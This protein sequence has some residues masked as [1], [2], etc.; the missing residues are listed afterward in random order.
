MESPSARADQVVI[1]E[2]WIREQL[3]RAG[4]S[5]YEATVA[6]DGRLDWREL[7]RLRRRGCPSA[8]ALEIVK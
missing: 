7:V 5:D 2:N 6:I 4:F 1:L 8:T 3:R